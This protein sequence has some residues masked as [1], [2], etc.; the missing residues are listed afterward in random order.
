VLNEVAKV[1]YI[2][3]LDHV[4]LRDATERATEVLLDRDSGATTCSVH[5]IKTPP[6]GETP[7]GFHTHE[8]DQLFYVLEGCLSFDIDG[9]EHTAGAS[10][11]VVLPA[12]V[13]HRNWNPG[14]EP[15]LHLAFNVPLPSAGEPFARPVGPRHP[16]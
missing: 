10:S 15:A 3:T 11:L 16:H 7:T 5:C 8:V 6:G 1:E 2:R 4:R 12:G 14:P 9:E 13:P